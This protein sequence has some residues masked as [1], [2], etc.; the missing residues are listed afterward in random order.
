MKYKEL[1]RLSDCMQSYYSLRTFN[2]SQC[3][4]EKIIE[5]FGSQSGLLLYQVFVTEG[6]A[7]QVHSTE[8][9]IEGC[10]KRF[11]WSKTPFCFSRGHR[12]GF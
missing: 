6:L 8:Y 11:G 10:F 9:S 1:N 3:S 4:D 7:R 2:F 5:A 12:L